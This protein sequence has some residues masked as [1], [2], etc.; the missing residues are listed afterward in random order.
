[1]PT[2]TKKSSSLINPSRF[3]GSKATL[4]AAVLVVAGVA[5]IYYSKAATP[6]CSKVATFTKAPVVGLSC[7][8]PNGLYKVVLPNGAAIFSHGL[9]VFN[10]P[11]KQNVAA[12]YTATPGGSYYGAD[13][14]APPC[15]S[16][17]YGHRLIYA[18]LAGQPNRYSS[19][20]SSIQDAINRANGLI[21]QEAKKFGYN[22][23]FPFYCGA[24]QVQL[25]SSD[26]S[27]STVV[28]DLY[29][30]GFSNPNL[31]Y[32]IYLDTSSCQGGLGGIQPDDRAT[33]LNYN[34]SGTAY[35]LNYGCNGVTGG[36]VM[37]H[38]AGHNLGAV[39]NSAPD[40]S[41]GWHCNDGTDLMCYSDGGSTSKYNNEV[42]NGPYSGNY[43]CNHNDYFNPRPATGSYLATH[44]NVAWSHWVT[45]LPGPPPDKTPPT[46][47][48]SLSGGPV[49]ATQIRLYWNASSD[50]ASGVAGYK[51]YRNGNEVGSTQE[52][53]YSFTDTGLK[54]TTYY[55]YAVRAYDN[56]GNLSADSN[57]VT[58]E[59]YRLCLYLCV[60]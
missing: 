58:I 9:D 42:C 5:A 12:T 31:H 14:V 32:W 45:G 4:L 50:D 17:G 59:T 44:W 34:N 39:Q 38:E 29:N 57:Q 19:L 30:K 3:Q 10:P 8:L 15:V 55:N 26:S 11:P 60:H 22:G 41:G 23:N 51:I 33:L 2:K 13:P 27:Y 46:A 40:A 7:R 28:N 35:A 43:D 48:T 52:P 56:A 1:M 53:T 25:S 47:P 21:H 49:N 16:S 36:L 20:S 24:D 37:A 6:D 54:A 18:Y